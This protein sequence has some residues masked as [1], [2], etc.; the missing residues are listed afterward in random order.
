MIY[1]RLMGIYGTEPR[2]HDV[3]DLEWRGSE[4]S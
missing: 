1:I 4:L 2:D 3:D